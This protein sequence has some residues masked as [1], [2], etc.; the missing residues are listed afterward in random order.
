MLSPAKAPSAPAAITQPSVR[1]PT[2]REQPGEDH[3]RLAR[4]G[5][6]DA[7]AEREREDDQVRLGRLRQQVEGGLEHAGIMAV[8]D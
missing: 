7:V 2:T 5:G 4:E 3:D 6:K 1:S 8:Q